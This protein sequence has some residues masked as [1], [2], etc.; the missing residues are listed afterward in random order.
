MGGKSVAWCGDVS[1]RYRRWKEMIFQVVFQALTEVSSTLWLM[2]LGQ[3][4]L[5]DVVDFSFPRSH[6]TKPQIKAIST[7][8]KVTLAV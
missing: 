3:F 2:A 4:F 1:S 5:V 8:R 7:N 6:D